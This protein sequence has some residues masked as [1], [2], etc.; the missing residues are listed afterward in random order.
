[1]DITARLAEEKIREAIKRGDLEGLPGAGSPLKFEDDS[2]VPDDKKLAYKI[3]KNAGCIPPELELKK[4]AATLMDLISTLDDGPER[5][6]WI[7]ELNFKL[8]KFNTLMKR[9]L[10]TADCPEY[11]ER[12]IAKISGE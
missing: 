3:L 10:N 4:E 1:M 6:R 9:P 11:E 2:F 7:R 8:L 5:T 12:I